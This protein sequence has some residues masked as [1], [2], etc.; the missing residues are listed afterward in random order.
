[1]VAVLFAGQFA[2]CSTRSPLGALPRRG[3]EHRELATVGFSPDGTVR[4]HALTSAMRYP[5]FG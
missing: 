4:S 2:D 5:I 3:G 1:M